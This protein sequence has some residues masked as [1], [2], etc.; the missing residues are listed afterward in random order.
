MGQSSEV[1]GEGVAAA[2]EHLRRP[3]NN[4][5]L[6]LQSRFLKKPVYRSVVPGQEVA[7]S[8]VVLA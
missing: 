3:I 5:H 8:I 7:M 1:V 4:F 6:L 2:V